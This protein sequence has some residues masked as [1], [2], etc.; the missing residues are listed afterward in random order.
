MTTLEIQA[1]KVELITSII[2]DV[3]DE[4]QLEAINIYLKEITSSVKEPPCQ[5][6]I[7]ELNQRA[8][9]AITD[10]ESGKRL[11]P[12]KQIKRKEIQ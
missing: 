2:N 7:T 3:D 8:E 5:Y 4:D 1:K 12:H 11:I 6:S 10:Y 9:R